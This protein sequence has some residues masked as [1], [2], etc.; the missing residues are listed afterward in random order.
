MFPYNNNKTKTI[1]FKMFFYYKKKTISCSVFHKNNPI[2]KI[3]FTFGVPH[4]LSLIYWNCNKN[5]YIPL[6]FEESHEEV[7]NHHLE[8]SFCIIKIFFS[9]IHKI[10]IIW[11]F[12]ELVCFKILINTYL[13]THNQQCK[14]PIRVFFFHIAFCWKKS[15]KY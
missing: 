3:K 13:H 7:S 1:L 2:K 5:A 8:L 14:K 11:N 4:F 15:E 6:K 10:I 9:E 12:Q